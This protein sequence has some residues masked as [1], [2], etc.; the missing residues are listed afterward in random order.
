MYVYLIQSGRGTG[1][2]IKIG[3]A[4]TIN[5][6]IE[7]LQTGNPEEIFLIVAF[8]ANSTA[9]AYQLESNL[10]KFFASDRIRGEWFRSVNLK[11]FNNICKRSPPLPNN[12][13]ARRKEKLRNPNAFL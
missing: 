3:V 4:K 12:K 2:P 13:K 10:H 1:R 5:K 9:H 11:K 8:R 6:R 7:S